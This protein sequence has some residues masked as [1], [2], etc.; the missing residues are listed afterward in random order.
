MIRQIGSILLAVVYFS[1]H[2]PGAYALEQSFWA[3]RRHRAGERNTTAAVCSVP[4]VGA[5]GFSSFATKD[6]LLSAPVA[7]KISPAVL[8]NNRDLF[9][10]LA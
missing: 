9:A 4:A 2:G 3:Q 7:E 1:I 10:V 6:D 8:Q 5:A